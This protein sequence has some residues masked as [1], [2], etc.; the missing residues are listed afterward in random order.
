MPTI[1]IVDDS[2][3]DRQLVGGLLRSESD[4]SIQFAANGAEALTHIEAEAPSVVVTDLIMPEMDGLELVKS[5][6]QKHPLIP[7]ILMTSKG[8]EEIAVQALQA[9]AASYAPKNSLAKTLLETIRSLLDV[10]TQQ[11]SHERLLQCMTQTDATFQLDN[12]YTLIPALIGHLQDSVTRIGLCDDN[13]RVRVGVALDEA[14]VNALYHGNLELS[15]E[16]RDSDHERYT[17]LARVRR[18]SAPYCD[19][20]IHV[21]ISL[22]P[23]KGSF[24]IRD[25]GPGFDPSCLPDPRDP[26]NLEQ[27]GGRGVLLM[28]TFMDEVSYNPHGN[29]V[30]MIKRHGSNSAPASSNGPK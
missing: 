17:Q 5:V 7:V 2:A 24:V 22:T 6:H 18:S 30:T 15:S 27:L 25:E 9:G 3:V 28:R 20:R 8:N 19:R 13:E 11:Q 21:R 10:S 16:M 26:A 1:L 14:L 29:E 23:R 12:D 4:F